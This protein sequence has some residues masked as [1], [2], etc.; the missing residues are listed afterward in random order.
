[1][2]L[3]PKDGESQPDFALRFHEDAASEIT[4]TDERN[5]KCFE[6]WRHA[7]GEPEAVEA[8]RYHKAEEFKELRNV[9]VFKEH[10][11]PAQ[12]LGN[13]TTRKGVT[14]DKYALASICK[15]MNDQLTEVGKCCPLTLGHTS[16][17]PKDPQPEVL[18]FT[19]SYRL[20]MV[21]NKKPKWA[22][23]TDEFHRKDRSELMKYSVGRSVE[24][25]PLPDVH[26]RTFYPIAV[27]QT[28]EP[29]LDLPPARYSKFVSSTKYCNRL[30]EHG[31]TIEV[32]RYEMALPGGNS[33]VL[34]KHV[35][36]DDKDRY[37]ED[38]EMNNMPQSAVEQICQ[39]IFQT[40]PFQYLIAKMEEDGK[41]GSVNPMVHQPPQMA[42]MP[43]EDPDTQPGGMPGMP[44]MD[45]AAMQGQPQPGGMT[46]PDA[47][48]DMGAGAPTQ[49]PPKQ[50][51]G[52]NPNKPPFD[53]GNPMADDNEKYSKSAGLQGLEARMEAM[54]AENKSLKAKLVGSE[55]YSKLS[56]LKA[57]GFELNLD[58]ELAR[59][60]TASDEQFDSQVETIRE[61]YRKSPTAVA[62]FSTI[63]GVGKQAE[64]P[65]GSGID[66]LTAGDAQEVAKY[67]LREGLGYGAARDRYMSDKKTGKNVAG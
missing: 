65:E 53:K 44:G 32:E 13:G 34:P 42:D 25:L 14:Y 23:F 15:N 29:R 60:T 31:N 46:P 17:N 4:N 19:G 40:A 41:A 2:H 59:A 1:M 36:S 67:A 22:I 9:C 43:M 28:E 61:H 64:L 48:S 30:D 51:A 8:R 62:D 38:S 35:G 20:G 26:S 52:G 54:E 11:V 27:L 3:K 50:F 57:E 5:Q 56:G 63:A 6:I 58:K 37:G 49:M 7:T 10:T 55:R 47:G 45:P 33:V 39:A 18:G 12:K 21:G 16:E 66:E 24:I